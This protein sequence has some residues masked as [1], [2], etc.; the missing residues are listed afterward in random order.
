[1]KIPRY[2]ERVP[3]ASGSG[4]AIQPEPFDRGAKALM[5]TGEMLARNSRELASVAL[6]IRE[7]KKAVEMARGRA[8]AQKRLNSFLLDIEQRPQDHDKF[9]EEYA[10][11]MGELAEELPE[12]FSDPQA[13]EQFTGAFM[14]LFE[15]NGR[16]GVA[17]M[18]LPK[19]REYTIA[20][21][22]VAVT[23][24]IVAMDMDSAMLALE[25]LRNI[26]PAP[27]FEARVK[28][29][30]EGIIMNVERNRMDAIIMEGG[31]NAEY[32]LLPESKKALSQVQIDDIRGDFRTKRN[33]AI[34]EQNL[35]YQQADEEV[36]AIFN[37]GKIPGMAM[38]RGMVAEGRMTETKALQW[39]KIIETES[40]SRTTAGGDGYASAL[41]KLAGGAESEMEQ[42]AI[43]E[44]RIEKMFTDSDIKIPAIRA[45][46]VFDINVAVAEK[47]MT[48]IMGNY[49]VDRAR[50]EASESTF[51][52]KQIKAVSK[53]RVEDALTILTNRGLLKEGKISE[54]AVVFSRNLM[55]AK[56]EKEA[57]TLAVSTIDE[58]N[59]N[60]SGSILPFGNAARGKNEI[61]EI[62][63]EISELATSWGLA[64]DAQEILTGASEYG[65]M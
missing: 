61:T 59:K 35:M 63:K 25:P 16:F 36:A 48:H 3:G 38:L 56:T 30:Q 24:A 21:A 52:L 54:I 22:D 50:A 5:M 7:S 33:M 57:M 14:P 18:A 8:Y 23:D 19:E 20:V 27:E 51:A 1:M 44:V 62:Y 26:L 29:A 11:M 37:S 17:Q 4:Q 32:D 34:S 45:Q 58:I 43:F 41:S 55:Q 6:E 53:S 10:S 46:L 42:K 13:L 2:S 60:L 15:E 39:K 49:L 12:I 64:E 40:E 65:G 28:K 31:V 9:E 47:K